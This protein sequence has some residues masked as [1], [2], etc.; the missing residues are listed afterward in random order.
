MDPV[1]R[2]NHASWMAIVTPTDR[3]KSVRNRCV[4][5]VLGGG[6]VLSRYFL[7]FSGGAWA[8]VILRSSQISSIFSSL[9]SSVMYSTLGSR[10]VMKT[11]LRKVLMK[12]THTP[13]MN[14]I[15]RMVRK[16]CGELKLTK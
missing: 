6:F 15:R 16:F 7:D 2:F 8:F 1:Y 9:L 12:G 11:A 13:N 10:K 5:K 3:P 14:V 4:I